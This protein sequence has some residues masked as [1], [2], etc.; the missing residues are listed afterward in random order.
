MSP[1][2]TD[3]Y[4]VLALSNELRNFVRRAKK[5]LDEEIRSYPTP[6]PRCDAQF[7]AAYEQ[8]SRLSAL[9]PELD[10]AANGGDME[11]LRALAAFAALPEIGEGREE[12]SLRESIAKVLA[13]ADAPAA[14]NRSDSAVHLTARGH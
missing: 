14:P 3:P 6:I 4:R 9:L 11:Q 1:V 13:A 10:A 2:Q 8:R 5:E 7:N 12:R